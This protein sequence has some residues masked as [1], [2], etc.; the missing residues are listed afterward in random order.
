[1]HYTKVK[2]DI[3]VATT[4]ADLTDKGYVQC[5]P[6]S[7]HQPYDLVVVFWTVKR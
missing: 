3:G 2:A 6:L 1:M 5:I 7:E 4:I